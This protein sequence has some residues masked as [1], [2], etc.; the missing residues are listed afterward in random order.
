ME[1]VKSKKLP[2]LISPSDYGRGENGIEKQILIDNLSINYKIIGDGNIPIILLHGWGISSDKYLELAKYLSQAGIASRRKS[3]LLI[4]A[5]QVLVNGVVEKN[6]ATNIKPGL[7]IVQVNGRKIEAA[8]KVYYML[9]KPV[10]YVC[11]LL[12]THNKKK[13]TDLIQSPEKIWPVG[14][15]DK[16]SCGLLVLTNDGELTNLLTHPRYESQKKYQ[17]IVSKTFTT[18]DAKILQQGVMLEEGLAQADQIKII[19]D[20]SIEITLHQGWKRQIRRMLELIGHKVLTLQRVQEGKL[21]L[22]DLPV[23]QYRQIGREDI[24]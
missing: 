22:G 11:S 20:T 21:L 15:L 3:E 5:G 4:L 23:G 12:D 17:V 1:N 2:L 7:D 6:V 10:G 13:V 18:K 24:V 16:D 19:N 8:K 14:R 9:N